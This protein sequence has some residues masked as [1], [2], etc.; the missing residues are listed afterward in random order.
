M[1]P[2]L[3][4]D[5]NAVKRAASIL[6]NKFPGRVPEV[7]ICYVSCCYFDMDEGRWYSFIG[8]ESVGGVAVRHE[9]GCFT[10]TGYARQAPSRY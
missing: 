8:A 5:V 2:H 6:I 10:F 9:S 3:L 4:L 1:I 7:M